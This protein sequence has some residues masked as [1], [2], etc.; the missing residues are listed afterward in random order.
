MNHFFTRALAGH[1][2]KRDIAAA[3]QF[4]LE[5]VAR[6]VVTFWIQKTGLKNIVVSGGVHANVKLNQRLH[7]IPGVSGLFVYPNMGD[8][9]C[10]TGAAMLAFGHEVMRAA[11]PQDA[12]RAFLLGNLDYLAAG[13]F[14]V[15]HRK[16]KENRADR[17]KSR[18]GT[19]RELAAV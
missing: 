14:L 16:L 12:V 5:E 8:G 6:R 9:G 3:Y 7:E 11:G 10:G 2:A 15:P 4:V 13:P 17:E 19:K 1:F 18:A